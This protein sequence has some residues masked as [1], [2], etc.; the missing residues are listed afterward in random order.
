M[1]KQK[2]SWKD[3]REVRALEE[4]K[5]AELEMQRKIGRKLT[6]RICLV[7][8]LVMVTG[9]AFIQI[10]QPYAITVDDES[11]IL[12]ENKSE[13]KDVVKKLMKDYTA[14]DAK[15]KSISINKNMGIEQKK[16]WEGIDKSEVVSKEEA[17]EHIKEANSGDE[18]LL[19]ATI[20]GKTVTEEEYTP[21]VKYVKD[22]NMFVGDREIEGEA[23]TGKQ[24]VTREITTVNGEIIE[25]E[26]TDTKIT[27][28]ADIQTVRVGVKGLPEGE[29]WKTYE[30][31]PRFTKGED[32][33][34]YGKKF[35]GNPY[36]KGGTSLTNG[37]DCVGFVRAMY[38]Y[39]GVS[40]PAT[41]GTVGKRVSTSDI[42][43]GDIVCYYRHHVALYLGD[44][45]IIHAA[46]PKKDICIGNLGGGIKQVRRVIY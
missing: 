4:S 40:L 26:V 43:P 14:T 13:A 7:A 8:F 19:V 21:E 20:V 38:K 27:E 2:N 42:R 22:E 36:V 18:D 1:N 34:E 35:L 44:G 3:V 16:I 6:R 32:L 28:K 37:C 10:Q 24:L 12:V 33:V 46:N 9:L 30:G 39:Y 29:D 23:S 41:L 31:D 11:V 5:G 17:V 25:T 15:I 45:K